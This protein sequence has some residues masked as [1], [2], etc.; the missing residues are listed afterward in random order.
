VVEFQDAAELVAGCLFDHVYHEHRFFYSADTFARLASDAGLDMTNVIR[1]PAQGGSLRVTLRPG[2]RD[3]QSRQYVSEPWLRDRAVYQSMQPRA[4]YL[5]SRLRRA[6]DAEQVAGRTVAGYGATAK[7]CTLL[8]F[9]GI[10]PSGLRYIADLTPSK[11]GR[12]TP[13]TGIPVTA[14]PARHPDTYLL[15]AWNYLAAVL[16]RERDFTGRWIV[17]FTGGTL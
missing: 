7:S 11:Q 16:R 13:G 4:E 15:L 5:R 10:G 2:L 8:N 12:Y 9:C 14:P 3:S 6:L 1:T 17:P